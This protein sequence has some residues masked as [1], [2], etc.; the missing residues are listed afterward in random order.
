MLNVQIKE[1]GKGAL[2]FACSC[3]ERHEDVCTVPF[4]HVM[5]CHQTI[6]MAV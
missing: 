5:D 2:V 1:S 3:A 4:S 6:S